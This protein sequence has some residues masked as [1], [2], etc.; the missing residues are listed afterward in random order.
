MRSV[1]RKKAIKIDRIGRQRKRERERE[2]GERWGERDRDREKD[3]FDVG[4]IG[5][6]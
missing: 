2:G 6:V 3:V 1:K 4:D 5:F